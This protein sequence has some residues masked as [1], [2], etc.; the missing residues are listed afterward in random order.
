MLNEVKP[1]SYR[2]RKMLD[3]ARFLLISE[4]AEAGGKTSEDIESVIDSA[5]AESMKGMKAKVEH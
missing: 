5:L 4:L 1:L 3:R 2:E